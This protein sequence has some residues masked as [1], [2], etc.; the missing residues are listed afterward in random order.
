MKKILIVEDQ[1][2]LRLLVRAT[3]EEEGVE[4]LECANAD[5]GWREALRLSPD[6]IVLDIMMPGQMDGLQLCR[7]LKT[8]AA[9]QRAKVVLISARGHRND[10]A[11]GKDAGADDYLMKPFSP[12]R[13]RDVAERL[14]MPA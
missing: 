6:L 9:T 5:E 3:L 10:M 7:R 8:T 14:L 2:E 11:I 12:A 4:I 13:L 1:P